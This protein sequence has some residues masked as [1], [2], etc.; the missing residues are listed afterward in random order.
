MRRCPPAG[1]AKFHGYVVTC[2]D[3]LSQRAAHKAVM[4]CHVAGVT[5]AALV[6]PDPPE[7]VLQVFT[8]AHAGI[9]GELGVYIH[10]NLR[11]LPPGAAPPWAAPRRSPPS[12]NGSV[13]IQ[14]PCCPHRL[15]LQPGAGA[16]LT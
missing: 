15:A 12:G 7:A 2:Y 13:H 9:H 1:A 4:A 10:I 14:L 16:I 3:G 6:G 5:L 8:T 11:R